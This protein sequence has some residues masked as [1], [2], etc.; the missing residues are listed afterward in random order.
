[1]IEIASFETIEEANAYA[2]IL[3][4]SGILCSVESSGWDGELDFA[5][6]EFGPYVLWVRKED[7]EDAILV[8][9]SADWIQSEEQEGQKKM[10]MGGVLSG[11]GLLTSFGELSAIPEPWSWLPY[12]LILAGMTI[13]LKGAREEEK[14]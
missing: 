9:E 4:K 8:L 13:F 5:Q 12:G 14:R 3:E 6:P 7:E 11:V 1:M 10:L 2:G